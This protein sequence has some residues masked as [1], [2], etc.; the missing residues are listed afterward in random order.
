MFNPQMLGMGQL[1]D[2]P[3]QAELWKDE[4]QKYRPFIIMFGIGI[5]I[6]F[7]LL[8][9]SF[10]LNVTNHSIKSDVAQWL[11]DMYPDHYNKFTDQA[12][13]ASEANADAAN[14]HRTYI[15][16]Y[17][18]ISFILLGIGVVLYGATVYESY[19]AKSFAKLS[20]YT[21]AIVLVGAI[22]AGYQLMQMAWS[23]D[24]RLETEFGGG[25]FQIIAYA[26][27]IVVAILGSQISKI[28]RVF[29]AS[30]RIE[31]LKNDPAFKAAQEQMQQMMNGNVQMGPFGPIMPQPQAPTQTTNEN[32]EVVQL[33]AQPAISKEQEK[34][35]NMSLANL[36]KVAK[37]LSIS[38]S[39][40]MEKKELI[41]A[42]LRVTS[43]NQ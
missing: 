25:I 33:P 41:E 9:A 42:I 11:Q 30:A 10:I 37:K 6:V 8:L 14:W 39:D 19:R 23:E 38:G 24:A 40:K 5:L 7:A 20:G 18:I 16:I 22:F 34:L 13:R 3:T 15:L 32:G 2:I 17:P 29:F 28:K 21:T 31:A 36:K 26:L 43:Q 27:M 35:E 4:K 1:P 12:I